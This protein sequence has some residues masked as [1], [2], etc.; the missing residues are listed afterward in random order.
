M[1]MK[2]PFLCSLLLGIANG[3]FLRHS[4]DVGIERHQGGADSMRSQEFKLTLDN[5]KGVQYTAPITLNNQTLRAVYDTGSF[6]IMAISRLCKVCSL[7]SGLNTYDNATSPTFKKGNRPIVD[8]HFAGGLVVARQDYETVLVGDVSSV[9]KVTNMA[10]WQVVDTNMPVWMNKKASFTA[11]VGLG[12]RGAVPDTPEDEK[13]MDSLIER[14]GTQRFAICLER[15]PEKPGYLVFNPAYDFRVTSISSMFRRINVVGNHHWAVTMNSVSAIRNDRTDRS[16]VDG[17]KCVAIIDSGTSLIGVPPNAV[18]MVYDIIQ[19]VKYDCSNLDTL[20]ELVFELDGHKFAMPGS[21]YTVQY[22][23]GADGKPQ[24]CLPAFTDFAMTSDRGTVWILGMPFLRH[25]YTVFDRE[26][27]S[28][29]VA[30][31]GDNCEPVSA[32]NA[33]GADSTFFNTT[34][35]VG[36]MRRKQQLPTIAD[37]SQAQLPSWAYGQAH[38]TL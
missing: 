25:F 7:P 5:H 17:N 10:F 32:Q 31:Q 36:G 2:F 28:I 24:R 29:Y 26:E 20:P 11:I 14:T 9:F 1:K 22:G 4:R 15:G 8:H 35:L 30:D 18:H 6:E 13:P 23:Q 27:P 16:C 37:M 21:A 12:H 38:L 3:V 19:Q 33:T 34:G